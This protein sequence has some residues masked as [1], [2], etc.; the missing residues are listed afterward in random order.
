[1]STLAIMR[2]SLLSL[3]IVVSIL[4]F[5]CH[6]DLGTPVS[7]GP[8][9]RVF[10][11]E[12]TPLVSNTVNAVAVDAQDIVW[13]GTDGGAST[14]RNTVWNFYVDQLAYT[15]YNASI[16]TTE[17]AVNSIA[18]GTDGSTWFGL[19]GG[20]VRRFLPS[21]T[22]LMWTSYSAEDNPPSFTGNNIIQL[23]ADNFGP[24]GSS[25]IWTASYPFGG[26]SRYLPRNTL[27]LLGD[28]RI[29]TTADGLPSNYITSLQVNFAQR[30]IWFG[31]GYGDLMSWDNGMQW[32]RTVLPNGYNGPVQCITFEGSNILWVGTVDGAFRRTVSWRF[33]TIADGLPSNTV[34]TIV[35]DPHGVKWIGTDGGLTRYDNYTMTTFN[36]TNSPLPDDHVNALAL[37]LDARIWIGTNHGAAVYNP[38]GK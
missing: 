35:V 22:N 5:G 24:N 33:F 31:S 26:A 2:I 23:V 17:H 28:W 16:P 32:V 34:H 30:T 11:K 7:P 12:T 18:F 27:P 9:W 3:T 38:D 13:F 21:S 10:T 25:E 6:Q 15:S 19:R 1:M 8:K 37:D 29:L 36:H 14:L 20:G 4:S